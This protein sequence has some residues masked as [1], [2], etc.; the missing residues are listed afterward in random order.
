MSK[1]ASVSAPGSQHPIKGLLT[2]WRAT[3]TSSSTACVRSGCSG[4]V[5]A[6]VVN[7]PHVGNT[8]EETQPAAAR[9][10]SSDSSKGYSFAG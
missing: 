7:L 2:Q 6:Q 8:R 5:T 4:A 10:F 1:L 9:N 3:M